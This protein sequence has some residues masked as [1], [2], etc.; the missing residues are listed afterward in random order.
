MQGWGGPGSRGGEG[1]ADPQCPPLSPERCSLESTFLFL[2]IQAP[3][4]FLNIWSWSVCFEVGC[5][6]RSHFHL[7][8]GYLLTLR[9]TEVG[10]L[11]QFPYCKMAVMSAA[12]LQLGLS[13]YMES[14]SRILWLFW[15]ATIYCLSTPSPPPHPQHSAWHVAGPR[16]IFPCDTVTSSWRKHILLPCRIPCCGPV[17]RD[18]AVCWSSVCFVRWLP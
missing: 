1:I 3:V 13:W 10:W 14:A 12:K 17:P 9:L 6:L 5:A 16:S 7:L 2:P 4:S 11:S 8:L 15:A 18:L